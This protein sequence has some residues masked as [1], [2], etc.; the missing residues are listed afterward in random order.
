MVLGIRMY[1]KI[2]FLCL[3]FSLFYGFD[4]Q[5]QALE[6]NHWLFGIKSGLRFYPD[7]IQP[8]SFNKS[9]HTGSAT[10]TVSDAQGNV[11]FYCGTF[12]PGGYASDTIFNA[13]NNPITFGINRTPIFSLIQNIPESDE[14]YYYIFS[15]GNPIYTG[16]IHYLWINIKDTADPGRVYPAWSGSINMKTDYAI[17]IFNHANDTDKWLVFRSDTGN[18]LYAVPITRNGFQ[19]SSMVTTQIGTH[20]PWNY[21]SSRPQSQIE[22]IKTSPNSKY[23][24]VS[25][26]YPV[27]KPKSIW[28]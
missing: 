1:S 14:D 7:S 15:N 23:L 13:K 3:F 18:Y 21:T 10:A 20:I 22:H 26:K 4:T 5:A 11:L 9:T 25:Y 12:S 16:T 27:D 2:L 8:V 19:F 6:A 28:R 24:A 17:S